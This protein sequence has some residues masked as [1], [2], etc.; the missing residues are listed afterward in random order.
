MVKIRGSDLLN[1]EVAKIVQRKDVNGTRFV[2]KCSVLNISSRSLVSSELSVTHAIQQHEI[3]KI[4]NTFQNKQWRDPSLNITINGEKVVFI[5]D[6]EEET[7]IHAKI[8]S[9]ERKSIGLACSSQFVA[10]V[11][12]SDY[13]QGVN[14]FL[15]CSIL[16]KALKAMENEH[17]DI[18]FS[19]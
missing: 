14:T 7:E 9:E 2:T 3:D 19:K 15:A 11:E 8:L 5:R 18:D 12:S 4:I 16:I 13:T 10:L 17:P 1:E 6:L